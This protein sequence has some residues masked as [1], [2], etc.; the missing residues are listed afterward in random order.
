MVNGLEAGLGQHGKLTKGIIFTGPP[1]PVPRP[2]SVT[3]RGITYFPP[4]NPGEVV[5]QPAYS[6]IQT[7]QIVQP[8]NIDIPRQGEDLFD[9]RFS[10]VYP[11]WLEA[12]G[13]QI[14]LNPDMIRA[15]CVLRGMA[16][17]DSSFVSF[18]SNPTMD[19]YALRTIDFLSRWESE[20]MDLLPGAVANGLYLERRK[21]RQMNL[22]SFNASN[23][24]RRSGEISQGF[25]QIRDYVLRLEEMARRV[26]E[27]PAAQDLV[28]I[29]DEASTI[30]GGSFTRFLEMAK[31]RGTTLPQ[32]E[33]AAA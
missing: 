9:A 18:K 3:I 23:L 31:E 4:L 20:R 8:T 6:E 1:P 21:L 2:E 28:T 14:G 32:E 16:R 19:L 15:A 11:K 26:L 25:D 27:R 7:C 33:E 22:T 10:L 30:L 13:G 17:D 12:V 29:I 5:L 24:E